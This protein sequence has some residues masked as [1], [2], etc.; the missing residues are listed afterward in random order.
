MK[1]LKGISKMLAMSLVGLVIMG[2]VGGILGTLLGGLGDLGYSAELLIYLVVIGVLWAK[3]PKEFDSLAE[4]VF[5]WVMMAFVG[6]VVAMILP[7]IGL[8]TLNMELALTPISL[9]RLLS[10]TIVGLFS[11]NWI[12]TA[13][14]LVNKK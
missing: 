4:L 12:L 2:A 1:P 5:V 9:A 6:T 13:A 10:L 7:T 11:A 8:A 3:L 14:G